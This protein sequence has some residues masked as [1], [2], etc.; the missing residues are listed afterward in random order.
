MKQIQHVSILRDDGD[1][2]DYE[3]LGSLN[4]LLKML[5]EY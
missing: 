2:K 1:N 5:K 3:M 4:C